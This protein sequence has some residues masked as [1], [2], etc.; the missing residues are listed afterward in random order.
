MSDAA[1]KTAYKLVFNT[2]NCG[3]V[4]KAMPTWGQS[5]GGVLNDEQMRQLAIFIT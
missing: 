2:I 3:R 5:Q 1:K 4:G